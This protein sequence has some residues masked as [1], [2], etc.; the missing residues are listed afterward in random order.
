MKPIL[1]SVLLMAFVAFVFV[2][3]SDESTS[4]VVSTSAKSGS[5]SSLMKTD[6]SGAWVFKYGFNSAF[7]WFDAN[8]GLMLVIGVNDFSSFCSGT[9]G[10]DWFSI[11]DIYLPNADPDLRRNVYQLHGKDVTAVVWDAESWPPNFCAFVLA[12][13]PLAEGTAHF[14]NTDNDFYAPD[15]ENPNSNA[16]GYKANGT[17]VGTDGKRYN[18]NLVYRVMWDGADGTRRNVVYKIQLTPTGGN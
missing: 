9:G 7:G 18:L 10:M 6:G 14:I 3:C 15:Q 13:D 8:S 17:L 2:G 16:W 4:P 5:N 11:N 12:N 1:S